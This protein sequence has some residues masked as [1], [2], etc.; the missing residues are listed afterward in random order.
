MTSEQSKK[1]GELLKLDDVHLQLCERVILKNINVGIKPGEIFGF[2]GVSGAGKTLLLELLIGY[3]CP[4]NGSV[5]YKDDKRSFSIF[6]SL[7]RTHKRFGFAPQTPSFY[8][9]LTVEE[10]LVYFGSLYGLSQRVVKIN[11]DTILGVMA[12]KKSRKIL[13]M[14]LSAGMKKRLNMAC[15]IVHNPK[16]LILDEPTSDL[17]IIGRRQVLSLINRINK[18]GTTVV[19][20]SQNLDDMEFLCHRFALVGNQKIMFVGSLKQL[21][22]KYAKAKEVIFESESRRYKKIINVLKK[23]KTL[24]IK[25]MSI[26][27]TKLVIYSSNAQKV[28]TYIVVMVKKLK[29]NISS[30]CIA[31]P[32]LEEMFEHMI[33]V[34][35]T[36]DSEE[37]D[38]EN[39]KENN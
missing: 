20:A 12:L 37:V 25:K 11:I 2:V 26:I 8:D 34:K 33:K 36:K 16:V 27:G 23:N 28:L 1:G 35:D 3:M 30:L 38:K 22:E 14:N 9:R 15:A 19:I 31:E 18:M 6:E 10:N 32:S 5:T 7:A 24:G 29:D 13:A 4:S 21:R 39:K 17:D